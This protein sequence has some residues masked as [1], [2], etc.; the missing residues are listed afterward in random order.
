MSYHLLS[1]TT[2]EIDGT[3]TILN[4]RANIIIFHKF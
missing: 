1:T 2:T 4:L 3:L